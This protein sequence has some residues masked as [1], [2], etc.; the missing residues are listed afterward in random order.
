MNLEFPQWRATCTPRHMSH[1]FFGILI[2]QCVACANAGE[3][4]DANRGRAPQEPM[5]SAEGTQRPAEPRP[6][7]LPLCW[8]GA[9]P[10][11]S[12]FD[13]TLEASEPWPLGRYFLRASVDHGPLAVCEIAFEPVVGAVTDTCDDEEL[14]F[15]VTYR[16]D[17]ET[18]AI[19]MLSFGGAFH[20]DVEILVAENLPPVVEIH[21]DVLVQKCSYVCALGEPL[22]VPVHLRSA[23]ESERDAGDGGTSDAA[24]DAAL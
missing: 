9:Y 15:R 1:R 7:D 14:G 21:H 18:R 19:Q 2:L 17:D 22:T 11:V 3:T 20:V 8:G 13:V 12:G 6:V 4:R 23:P 24:T 16:Y 5:E 10:C